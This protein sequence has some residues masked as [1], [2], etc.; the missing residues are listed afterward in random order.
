MTGEPV[1][2]PETGEMLEVGHV[3][4]DQRQFVN[5]GNVG[6]L[7]IGKGR[8]QSLGGE[9]GALGGMPLRRLGRVGKDGQFGLAQ[10]LDESADRIALARGRE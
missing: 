6:D 5:M 2:N 10:R 1:V 3:A 4:R 8:C 9:S 7:A